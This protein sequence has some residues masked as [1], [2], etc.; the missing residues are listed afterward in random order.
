MKFNITPELSL[1]IRTLRMQND[2]PSKVLAERIGRSPSY[3]T[4]V[5]K[6]D[7]RMIRDDVLKDILGNCC[8]GESF[9]PDKFQNML[10]VLSQIASP[11]GVFSQKWLL[12]MDMFDRPVEM[13]AEMAEDIRTRID[14]LG[15]ST[16]QVAEIM[17]AN[18][19]LYGA[20]DLPVNEIVLVESN[21]ENGSLFRVRFFISQ[22]DFDDLISGRTATTN[23]ETCYNIAFT[24]N[25]LERFG[26]AGHL[27]PDDAREVLAAA[28]TYL[29]SHNLFSMTRYGQ[30][31]ASS[32]FQTRQMLLL[33]TFETANTDSV[34][35]IVDMFNEIA[36]MDK[37]MAAESVDQM[38]DNMEWDP[39]FMLSLIGIRFS[40]LGQLSYSKKKEL[41]DEIRAVYRRYYDMPDSEK[42]LEKY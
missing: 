40:E 11:E 2:I 20:K 15:F 35:G 29:A 34:S 23:Y 22:E 17:N 1:L 18:K 38:K 13:P 28:N 33:N 3:L 26:D 14:R 24:V 37:V 32:E 6:G 21:S 9:Y 39:S 27:E 8:E 41:L 30:I 25:K 4:K 19:D 36:G 42:K 16:G 10:K 5:E 7:V 31:L 12:Q